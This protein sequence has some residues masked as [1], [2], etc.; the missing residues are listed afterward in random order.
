MKVRFHRPL[1]LAM[2]I[3]T[4]LAGCVTTQTQPDG[5]TRLRVSIADALGMKPASSPAAQPAAAP[6]PTAPPSMAEPSAPPIQSTKLVGLFTQ[7]PYDG[8]AA[9]Y[10][11][12]VAVTVTDWSRSDCWNARARIWWS[13]VRSEPVPRFSV[14]W[15]SSLGFALNN[16]AKLHMFVEQTP[17]VDQTGNVRTEGPKPPLL[18]VPYDTAPGRPPGDQA[19]SGFVEQLVVDTGWGAGAPTNMW[20]VAYRKESAE[21]VAPEV[22]VPP[23][24][25]KQ[26]K[27]GTAQ[28][29]RS[30]AAGGLLHRAT[31]QRAFECRGFADDFQ[32]AIEGNHIPRDGKPLRLNEPLLVYGMKVNIVEYFGLGG[33][34][35][36]RSY[37]ESN[38]DKEVVNAASAIA[39]KKWQ[40]TADGGMA[41][42]PLVVHPKAN[43]AVLQCSVDTEGGE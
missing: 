11:P 10:F 35:I 3:T 13:S 14:C 28:A 40:R 25:N 19:F 6:T 26:G 7:H 1:L 42:G 34:A 30:K 5:S 39:G 41:N 22:H 43:G 31:L 21:A 17:P 32:T 4:Q 8:T 38:T 33:E 37:F 9:S 20:I 24:S 12:R 16:A 29:P 23:E 36:L 15:R 2:S 27:V 18:A